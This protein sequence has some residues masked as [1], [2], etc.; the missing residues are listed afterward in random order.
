MALWISS[1]GRTALIASAVLYG[2]FVLRGTA[3]Q[4][5]RAQSPVPQ[6]R[7]DPFWPQALPENWILGEVSGVAVDSSDHVWIL[8]RPRTL[9]AKDG[10]PPTSVCCV[11][12]PPVIE[13]DPAG[14]VVQAWGG[15]DGYEWPTREHG[16]SIDPQGNVWVT[17]TGPTEHIVSKF[18]RSGKFLMDLGRRGLTR[19]INDTE[20][21]GAPTQA[22]VDGRANEVYVADG[23]GSGNANRRVIVFDATTGAYKRRWNAYGT[24][25]TGPGP[26]YDPAAPPPREFV[27]SVHCVRISRDGL[28]YVCD[29]GADRIQVFRKDGTFVNELVIAQNTIQTGSTWDL[30]FTPDQQFLLVADGANQKVWIVQRNSMKVVGSFGRAGHSAGQLLWPN[31]I[32]VDSKGN[33]FVCE[34]TGGNRVQKFVRVY[35]K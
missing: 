24:P 22:T 23:E 31:G 25:T 1:I 33:V 10:P 15:S 19:G 30:D 8:H 21:L 27:G 18:T 5:Q 11:P 32:A 14:K 2:A 20:T 16:I 7:V 6:Y 28:V 34:V 3:V 12:A 13:F 35:S 29:R 17:F 26:K 4:A 9:T